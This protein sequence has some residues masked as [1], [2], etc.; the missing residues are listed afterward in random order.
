MSHAR[1]VNLARLPGFGDATAPEDD[2][3]MCPECLG[4]KVDEFNE[5]C[6]FCGGLGYYVEEPIN[7]AAVHQQRKQQEQA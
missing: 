5:P 7:R 1:F 4:D 2:T 6:I 3:C